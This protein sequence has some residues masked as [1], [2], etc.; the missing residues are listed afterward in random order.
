MPPASKDWT[1]VLRD[2][3]SGEDSDEHDSLNVLSVQRNAHRVSEL[4]HM[5][6]PGLDP[7][8]ARTPP[9]GMNSAQFIRR[10][11]SDATAATSRCSREFPASRGVA[12]GGKTEDPAPL[13]PSSSS[14]SNV[15]EET[16][17]KAS[18]A[19]ASMK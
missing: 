5:T 2:Y 12:S 3:S 7:T 11:L 6:V 8:Q 16:T 18:D 15:D 13:P 1:R 17:S 19:H 4:L 10:G 9:M 14:S